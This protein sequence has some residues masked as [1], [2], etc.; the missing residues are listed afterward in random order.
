LIRRC[1]KDYG[2][3]ETEKLCQYF[4][5]IPPLC[6]RVNTT[7][8]SRDELLKEL[9]EQGI[10]ARPTTVSPDGIYIDGHLG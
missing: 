3:E 7:G 4:D 5:P 2:P 6:L 9:V 8:T 10:H 1:L